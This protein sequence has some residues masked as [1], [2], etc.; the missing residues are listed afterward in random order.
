MGFFKVLKIVI[1]KQKPSSLSEKNTH[2]YICRL[3]YTNRY[4][5]LLYFLQFY[6]LLQLHMK[7]CRIHSLELSGHHG[8]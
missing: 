3:T 6:I 4:I 7:R 5:I 8:D 2:G 1:K